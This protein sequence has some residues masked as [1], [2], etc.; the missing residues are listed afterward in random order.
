MGGQ[1]H[2]IELHWTHFGGERELTVDG[3]IANDNTIP[4][5][6]TLEQH[7]TIGGQA[8]RVVTRPQRIKVAAFD[9]E[10]YLGDRLIPPTTDERSSS[11]RRRIGRA[12]PARGFSPRISLPLERFFLKPSHVQPKYVPG[13]FRRS[14]NDQYP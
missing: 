1:P 12:C 5:R 8:G 4:L 9:I 14:S 13:F 2:T 6:W 3:Q 11:D 7:F 10:I